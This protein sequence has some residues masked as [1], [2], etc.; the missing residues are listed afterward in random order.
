MNVFKTCTCC[1]ESW[2][3]RDEF[4][5]DCDIELVGYQI[6]FSDLRLGHFL[7]NHLTCRSTI[8]VSA[9]RFKSLY[10]G[11]VFSKRLT[12]SETCPGYCLDKENLNPCSAKCECS[13]VRAVMQI[14]RDWPKKYRQIPIAAKA[15]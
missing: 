1:G 3:V 2:F 5:K 13:Y 7:F 12:G 4:L 14:V 11:P 8:A 9:G 10:G 15:E 6:N